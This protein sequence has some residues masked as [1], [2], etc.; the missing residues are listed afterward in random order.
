MCSIAKVVKVVAMLP[1][2][3]GSAGDSINERQLIKSMQKYCDVVVYSLLSVS[4]ISKL[5]R[6]SPLSVIRDD[7]KLRL[8]LPYVGYPYT[9][10]LLLKVFHGL[11]F[12]ILAVFER[13]KL[14]YVRT[15]ELALFPILFRR[16][17]RA[18][19]VVKIPSLLEEEFKGV[20]NVRIHPLDKKI[21]RSL[22][23]ALDRFAISK[24]DRIVTP[25]LLFYG[26]LCRRRR[27]KSKTFPLI[28]PPGVDLIKINKIRR[29][30]E[31]ESIKNEIEF[32]VGY[33]GLLEWWQGVDTLAKAVYI[34][35][36][37]VGTK[38][39]L[40]IIGD[41]PMRK[42][43][44]ALCKELKVSC[45]IT[46]FM[47]HDDVLRM[48]RRVNVLVVPSRGTT[49]TETVIPIK[50]VEAWAL[51]IPVIISKHRIFELLEKSFKKSIVTCDPV[52][53]SVAEAIKQVM[54]DQTLVSQLVANGLTLAQH[55]DY[56]R[57]ARAILKAIDQ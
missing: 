56:E 44:E 55:F 12:S 36:K 48:L 26:E 40:L 51:G 29:M 17:H 30:S 18:R 19:V 1:N 49:N 10:G 8:L 20:G 5:F 52:P 23:S 33:V 28:A 57:T 13:P 53:K 6:K 39:K 41:G 25:S 42:E 4:D 47:P 54:C 37:D 35:Q 15:S 16:I 2:I 50:V 46:G 22:L 3:I 43:I 9:I 7:I 38:L 45:E 32:T 11:V 24:A 31:A 14:I 21:S 27:V 34:L